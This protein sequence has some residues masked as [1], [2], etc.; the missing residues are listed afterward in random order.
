MAKLLDIFGLLR[1]PR[2][3]E[4][5][6]L[7]FKPFERVIRDVGAPSGRLPQAGSIGDKIKCQRLDLAT[8]PSI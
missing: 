3:V 5:I 8:G 4:L 2:P 6:G 7:D 1:I